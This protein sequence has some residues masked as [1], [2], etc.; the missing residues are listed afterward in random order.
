MFRE[1]PLIHHQY[2]PEPRMSAHHMLI[3][4]IGLCER[5][6]FNHAVDAMKLCKVDGFLAIE[7][8]AGGPAVD[9]DTLTDHG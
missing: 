3:R 6:F 4:L 5:E 8:V 1:S 2:A 9:G 7:C